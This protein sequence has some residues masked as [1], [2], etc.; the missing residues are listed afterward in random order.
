MKALRSI[1]CVFAVVLSVSACFIGLWR[2]AVTLPDD[3]VREICIGSVAYPDWYLAEHR[4]Q[5]AV[6]YTI[7]SGRG[8]TPWDKRFGNRPGSWLYGR[9]LSERELLL[10][11]ADGSTWRLDRRTGEVRE[12]PA[13]SLPLLPLGDLIAADE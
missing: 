5:G 1:G 2:Y 7:G 12:D 6:Y 11:R 4:V 3:A 13:P 8:D 10:Q 9:S